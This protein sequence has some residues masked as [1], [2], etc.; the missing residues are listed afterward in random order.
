MSEP[1]AEEI[2]AA[3]AAE[4]EKRKQVEADEAEA[5]ELGEKGVAALKEERQARKTAEKAAKDAADELATLRKEKADAD[6]AKAKADA[7][8]AAAKGEWEKLAT[9]R[10]TALA[11]KES[12]VKSLT[13]ERDAL[14]AR[15]KTFE[16][17]VAAEI[18]EWIKAHKDQHADLMDYY[19]G[20]DATLEQKRTWFDKTRKNVE[21]RT[22]NG[23]KFPKTPNATKGT[24]A[25]ADE[26]AR[27]AASRANQRKF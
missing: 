19:P 10:E 13:E 9:E 11:A 17:A 1:T 4:D 12:A 8:D 16:D 25:K 26:A 3:K 27:Q 24:D 20:D 23:V 6:A 18:S 14:L 15:V 7:E 2:A 22:E 21:S 5:K